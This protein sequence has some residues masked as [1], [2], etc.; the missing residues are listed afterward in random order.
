LN[1]YLSILGFLFLFP[2][3]ARSQNLI[4]GV[5]NSYYKVTSLTSGTNYVTCSEV[6]VLQAG[7]KV[8]LIQMT[9]ASLDTSSANWF[10][11]D[12]SLNSFPNSGSYEFLSVNYVS[13][14]DVYFTANLKKNYSSNERIQLVKIFEAE[15]AVVSGDLTA[16][17]WDSATGKGGVIALVILKNLVLNANITATGKGFKGAVPEYYSANC[18]PNFDPSPD[19]F[20]FKSSFLNR[21]GR[22][23][24]GIINAGFDYPLG[25]GNAFSGGGG[26]SGM[27]GGGAGGSNYGAGGDGSQQGQ[28]CVSSPSQIARRGIGLFDLG[29]YSNANNWVVMGG[30]GGSSTR[31]VTYNAVNGGNG[32]GLIFILTD[33]LFGNGYSITS[34]GTPS[35]TPSGNYA[36]G[37]GG[38]A[39]GTILIDASAYSNASNLSL[40]ANGGRG[41][42]GGTASCGGSGGG[43]GG[44]LIW[45][46]GTSLPSNVIPTAIAGTNGTAPGCGYSSDPG[47]S[48]GALSQLQPVLN[49]FLFNAVR[50]SDTICQGQKPRLLIG[51]TPKGAG[52]FTYEWLESFD[53]NNW[54]AISSTNL[55]S[56]QPDTLNS[57]RYFTRVVT[58]GG[59]IDTALS[60]KIFVYR[61]IV[62]NDLMLRDTICSGAAPGLL[63]AKTITDGGN[64]SYTYKWYSSAD[65]VNWGLPIGTSEEHNATGILTSTT[66]YRRIVTSAVVCVDTSLP[67]TTT[68]LP[69]ITDNVFNIGDTTICNNLQAG[70]LTLN[71]PH[72]GQEGQ[73]RYTWLMRINSSSYSPVGGATASD[74]NAGTLTT[75][76]YYYKRVVLSGN[77]DACKDTSLAHSIIVLPSLYDTTISSTVDLYC[78]N[79]NAAPITGLVPGGG[80]TDDYRYKWLLFDGT[81]FFPIPGET[82]QN[83]DPPFLI[84]TSRYKR[85][86]TSGI[87][88]ACIS[89]SNEIELTVIPEITNTLVSP[90]ETIC[91][92]STP[93]PFDET[94]ASD[95]VGGFTYK[96]IQKTQA[97]GWSAAVGANTNYF[98]SSP[99]IN[100]HE[101]YSF[102]RVA[103]SSICPDTS[104]VILITVHPAISNNTI[105]GPNQYICYNQPKIINGSNPG[106]GND[107][108]SYIWQSSSNASVWNPT[109]GNLTTFTTPNLVTPTYYRRIVHSGSAAECKDTS[110]IVLININPLPTG[111]IV[112]ASDTLCDGADLIIRYQSLTGSSPWNLIVSDGNQ[113]FPFTN[114]VAQSG[115]LTYNPVTATSVTSSSFTLSSLVDDS[116]CAAD[117]SSNIGIVEATVYANPLANAGDD[118]EI[119]GLDA[120][121]NA[122][123]PSFGTGEWQMASGGTF[124][125]LTLP[126]AVVTSNSYGSQDIVWTVSNWT[127]CTD[128]DVVMVTFYE[129]PVDIEAGEDIK[130]I[131]YETNLNATPTD[132]GTGYW[133]KISTDKE[134]EFVDSTLNNT[135]VKLLSGEAE[136]KFLWSIQNGICEV[137]SDSV[138]VLVEPS[139]FYQGFSPD[140]NGI[141]DVFIIEFTEGVTATLKIYNRNG[142][143]IRNINGTG[144]IEWDGNMENGDPLPDDT[145]FYIFERHDEGS[146]PKPG[147][148]ELRRLN[149]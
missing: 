60:I 124:N 106:G 129:Q 92:N 57:T 82:L 7:D 6:P 30:G 54:S 66:Y 121:L 100:V 123:N 134:S 35:V 25:I 21:A 71:N 31:N 111:D 105:G 49:G 27:F 59:I 136:Y 86:V 55:K 77:H 67:D 79:T 93:Q 65:L 102:S 115:T 45:F 114:I 8:L 44:G 133:Q 81:Q 99:Q 126:N 42:N 73:Y 131:N 26:G 149:K 80:Q 98:Y 2:F 117:L 108:Y 101:L 39:G 148:V 68:V 143:W 125:D 84:A 88:D 36:G 95:G 46:S 103:T 85:Q 78:Y 139:V 38:G 75:N 90:D 33:T 83:Y 144:K 112:S 76:S 64:G 47:I 12:G 61:S 89:L 43:G 138:L 53:G 146:S 14:Q 142:L 140:E 3:A 40:I 130:T 9:G 15:S 94:A 51:T 116:L 128:Q 141:N 4:S 18:R 20:Y 118:F 97:T 91:E 24:E 119:C 147:F 120:Q 41:G 28:S 58:S 23:G 17:A 13:G 107:S 145:Y 50:E 22:K 69:Q 32:G 132:I 74:Y 63:H 109:T 113:S 56:Y 72:G 104:N 96:W 70:V 48:G 122:D 1:R 5:V 19:T 52:S 127:E 29:F 62:G 137:I 16:T 135:S 34:N 37:G 110:A 11:N 10:K 87:D